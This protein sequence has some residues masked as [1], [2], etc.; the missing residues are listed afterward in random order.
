MSSP[1]VAEYFKKNDT[2][3]FAIGSIENHGAHNCLGV[4]TLIPEHILSIVEQ[5]CEVLIVPTLPYGS[6]DPLL[7]FAGTIS[8]GPEVL[9]SV[10]DK[11]LECLHMFGAR[12]V[13]L[14]NGHDTNI[15]TLERVGLDWYKKG[16]VT[17][18]ISWWTILPEIN[19][20]WI[21]GH[22][23]AMETSSMMAVDPS[24]VD[25]SKVGPINMRNDI[26]DELPSCGVKNV[27]FKGVEIP[28]CR[29]ITR[30]T[31][32][33]WFGGSASIA[34]APSGQDFDH[35]KDSSA[36]WGNEMLDGVANYIAEF[37]EAFKRVKA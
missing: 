22:G 11:V 30:I 23:G 27:K 2:V 1:Q 7:G 10:V 26:S 3:I 4:D 20:E 12:K 25:L 21:G 34:N 18:L 14:L 33:G 28:L 6:T 31:D 16:L 19:P 37:V 35:P 15:S 9:Y 8:L 36:K 29:P 17:A 5:K 32:N 24:L 13:L